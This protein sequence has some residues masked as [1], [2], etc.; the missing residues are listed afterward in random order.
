[1]ERFD[2]VPTDVSTWGRAYKD[3]LAS[4]YTRTMD[5]GIT[6]ETLPHT[7]N[8]I[9][10]DPHFRDPRG[11]PLPRLTFSFHQNESRMHRFMAEVGE[12][13]MRQTG[14]SKVWSRLP[15]RMATRW[16]GGTRMGNDPRR[17]VVNGYCQSHDIHNLFILGASVFPTLTAYPATATIAALSYRT[18]EYIVRQKEW[19]R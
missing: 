13:I 5:I 2:I 10:L 8:R 4:Y 9:D 12:G 17:S 19:F 7:D 1:M 15:G 18:A 14:A 3:Y 6:P 16:A 11:I